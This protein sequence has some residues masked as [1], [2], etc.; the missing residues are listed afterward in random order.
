MKNGVSK[1]MFMWIMGIAFVAVSSVVGFLIGSQEKLETKFNHSLTD[2]AQDVSDMKTN[3][4]DMK[5][6]FSV[7]IAEIKTT[8]QIMREDK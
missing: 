7:G 1:K 8:L 3:I 4:S 2:M 6:E 5:T